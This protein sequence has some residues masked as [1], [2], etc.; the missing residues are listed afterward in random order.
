MIFRDFINKIRISLE[1]KP[2]FVGIPFLLMMYFDH[3]NYVRFGQ[4]L[5]NLKWYSVASADTGWLI[6]KY[7]WRER[8]VDCYFS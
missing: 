6:F 5:G 4:I 7:C 8:V 3:S 1:T 2:I